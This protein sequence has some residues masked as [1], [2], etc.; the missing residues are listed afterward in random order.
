LSILRVDGVSKAF[1]GLFAVNN[2]SFE[3]HPGEILSIIGPNG[4]G[5]STLFNLI[6]RIYDVTRGNIFLCGEDISMTAPYKLAAMG[7]S[8]TFQNI[9][10]FEG[11][12]TLE[13]V[14]VG[15]YIRGKV[16]FFESLFGVRNRSEEQ[17]IKKMAME[18]IHLVG[19][20]DYVDIEAISLPYGRQRMVEIARA[21]M[22]SPSLLLLD[23]PAAG[24]NSTE[25]KE[26]SQMLIR[27]RQNGMSIILI[28][29]DMETVMEISDRI[30][31]VNYGEKLAEGTPVE[32]QQN[33][34]VISAYLGEE[35]I[36]A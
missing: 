23:E 14:M 36:D 21:L 3:V 2:V 4:A 19:L 13:N 22:T 5:K 30:I 35:I 1:G 18:K 20:Q 34:E 12:T 11:L 29:H 28:E 9:E 25:S 10:L 26:L 32:I 27:L 17:R 15:G 24:L 6:T 7:M 31:V 16:G 8:R 33:Q